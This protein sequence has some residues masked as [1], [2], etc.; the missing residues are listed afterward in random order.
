V[1]EYLDLEDLLLFTRMLGAG[2]VR[3]VGLLESA[4][5]RPRTALFGEDA[6]HTIEEK[7][8]ALLH[9]ICKNH[10]LVDGNK[11]LALLSLVTFLRANGRRVAWTQDQAFNLV[12]KVAEGHLEVREIAGLLRE[13]TEEASV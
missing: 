6:Y 5:A 2:P 11:R 4:V 8:A 9:S 3:D 10:A 1:R 12:M 7:A 13:S